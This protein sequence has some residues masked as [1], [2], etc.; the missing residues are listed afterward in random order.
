[1]PFIYVVIGGA[2]ELRIAVHFL[3]EAQRSGVAVPDWLPQLPAVGHSLEEWWRANLSDPAAA[4]ELLGRFNAALGRRIGEALRRG[5][6][7]PA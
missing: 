5:D 3:A 6:R 4:Q 1:M 2:R 7:S